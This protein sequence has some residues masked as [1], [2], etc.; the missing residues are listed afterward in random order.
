M[1]FDLSGAGEVGP[2]PRFLQAREL[3]RRGI[4]CC[5]HGCGVAVGLRFTTLGHGALSLLLQSKTEEVLYL[6]VGL[7]FA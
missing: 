3:S 1:R 4:V 6:P 2:V 5:W 7:P